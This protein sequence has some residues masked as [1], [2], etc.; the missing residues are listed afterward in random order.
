MQAL[1]GMVAVVAVVALSACGSPQ[2]CSDKDS[3]KKSVNGLKNVDLLKSGGPDRL[4][5]QLQKVQSDAKTL[6]KSAKDDFPAETGALRSSV[7]A[8]ATDVKQIPASPQPAQLASL[9]AD[10]Q[11]VISSFGKFSDAA[12]EKC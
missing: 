2:Y 9:G 11:A 10:I 4:K 1:A 5:Q 3:L 7:T 6:A 12:K 8:L